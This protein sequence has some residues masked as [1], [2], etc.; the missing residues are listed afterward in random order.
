MCKRRLVKCR[1]NIFLLILYQLGNTIN[2][3]ISYKMLI[4]VKNS[5]QYVENHSMFTM[6]NRNDSLTPN[7]EEKANSDH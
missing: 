3:F 5:V 2:Y 7:G 6:E 4:H 1:Y